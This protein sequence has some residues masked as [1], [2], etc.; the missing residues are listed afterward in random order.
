[1]IDSPGIDSDSGFVMRM[2]AKGVSKDCIFYEDFRY[3]FKSAVGAA[4]GTDSNQHTHPML[5]RE[6]LQRADGNFDAA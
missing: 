1:M 2:V 3:V 6:S 4:G 5:R